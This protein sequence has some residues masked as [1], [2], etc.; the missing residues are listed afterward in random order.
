MSVSVPLHVFA[1]TFDVFRS[2]SY[3]FS[4]SPDPFRW[5]I[6]VLA[7]V[8]H[9]VRLP[10]SAPCHCSHM[11]GLALRCGLVPLVAL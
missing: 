11:A 10:V 6:V 8:S 1:P 9:F 4:I 2:M 5:P 7:P 3:I